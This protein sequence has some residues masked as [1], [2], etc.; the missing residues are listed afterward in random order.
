MWHERGAMRDGAARILR[1]VVR[2]L[3]LALVAY[4]GTTGAALLLLG[5]GSPCGALFEL[6]LRGIRDAG[7]VVSAEQA[8]RYRSAPIT[9]ASDPVERLS[10]EGACAVSWWY[11]LFEDDDAHRD[12]WR[13]YRAHAYPFQER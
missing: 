2:V 10:L 3:A 11:P 13:N 8:E 4:V 6:Q 7:V 12:T 9:D 1:K 5:T